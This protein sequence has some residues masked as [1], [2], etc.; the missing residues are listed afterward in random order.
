MRTLTTVLASSTL[1]GS[2][3]PAFSSTGSIGPIGTSSAGQGFSIS[4]FGSQGSQGGPTAIPFAT[5]LSMQGNFYGTP[6]TS[7]NWGT[8]S[9]MG[10]NVLEAPMFVMQAS[11]L[12]SSTGPV[13]LKDSNPSY[14]YVDFKFVPN[15]AIG[16]TGFLSVILTAKG[17]T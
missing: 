5:S 2:S 17:N 13:L 12:V 15:S 11:A 16:S 4:T 1:W 9:I 3:T 7:L 6:S 14:K 8:F 10:S